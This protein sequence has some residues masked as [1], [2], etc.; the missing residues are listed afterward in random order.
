MFIYV[1]RTQ[2][3]NKHIH[4]SLAFCFV[5]AVLCSGET[6]LDTYQE[7]DRQLI[8]HCLNFFCCQTQRYCFG[9]SFLQLPFQYVPLSSQKTVCGPVKEVNSISPLAFRILEK[10]KTLYRL[11]Y[12]V[13]NAF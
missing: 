1:Y 13:L 11:T 8:P 2:G 12:S 4:L 9:I 7:S 5:A 10:E 3:T 6:E